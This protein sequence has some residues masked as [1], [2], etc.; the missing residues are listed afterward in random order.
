MDFECRNSFSCGTQDQIV[1]IF[2]RL[3]ARAPSAVQRKFATI[4]LLNG[5]TST[6]NAQPDALHFRFAVAEKV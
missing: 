2:H 3:E 1:L 6:L 5:K 4:Y